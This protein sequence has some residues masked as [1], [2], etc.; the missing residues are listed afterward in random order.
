LRADAF[1]DCGL[2][3]IGSGRRDLLILVQPEQGFLQL[4]RRAFQFKP[5][6]DFMHRDAGESE[7]AVLACVVGSTSNDIA[8]MPFEVFGKDMCIEES[9]GHPLEHE[10][11]TAWASSFF[12]G[13]MDDF[14]NQGGVVRTTE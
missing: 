8:V 14:V 9:F 4:S 5:V 7:Y 2:Q 11:R 12:V 1:D 6:N 13:D 10:R 3:I